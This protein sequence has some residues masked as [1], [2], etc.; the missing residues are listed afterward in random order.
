MHRAYQEM[1]AA[2]RA[3]RERL[4]DYVESLEWLVADR[5]RAYNGPVDLPPRL[6]EPIERKLQATPPGDFEQ[7]RQQWMQASERMN[8]DLRPYNP[9]KDEF[10]VTACFAG[11]IPFLMLAMMLFRHL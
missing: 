9:W 1:Q 7:L 3:Q 8:Q 4:G 6:K 5:I 11:I 10:V 2:D